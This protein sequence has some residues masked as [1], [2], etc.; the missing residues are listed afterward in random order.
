MELQGDGIKGSITE[1]HRVVVGR[2][3]CASIAW[4]KRCV[5]TPLNVEPANWDGTMQWY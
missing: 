2:E 1:V 3:G 4:G 5:A